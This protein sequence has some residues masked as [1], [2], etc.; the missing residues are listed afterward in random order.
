MRKRENTQKCNGAASAVQEPVCSQA[1]KKWTYNLLILKAE[2]RQMCGSGIIRN[3]FH[4]LFYTIFYSLHGFFKIH[5][6][7]GT[8]E[9]HIQKIKVG[10][11]VDL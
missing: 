4:F 3:F 5:A 1:D 7:F 8:K 6:I 9:N 11:S 2:L 10:K